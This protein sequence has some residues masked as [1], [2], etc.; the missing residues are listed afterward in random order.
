MATFGIFLLAVIA[1]ALILTV[2]ITIV[3][4]ISLYVD[5]LE[6]L[7]GLLVAVFFVGLICY[8]LG[9]IAL[10]QLGWIDGSK[11]GLK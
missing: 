1:G 4:V 8:L 2:F 6:E 9:G 3:Y 11:I 7:A 5:N 10:D